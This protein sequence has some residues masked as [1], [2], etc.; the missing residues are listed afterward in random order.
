MR[1]VKFLMAAGAASMMS[2]VALAAD[3]PS[4]A[5]P[6]QM[7]YAPPPAE[8]F[9]GW[10]LRGD[11]GMTN[12]NVKF[13]DT[14]PL[15]SAS[16]DKG[17]DV[18]SATLFGLGVG[19]QFNSW[20]RADV[21]GQY[22]GNAAI[23][24]ST[25]VDYGVGGTSADSYSGNKQE[26]LILANGYVDLGTWW[27]VTP[28]VGAGVGVAN[29][30][31]KGFRDDG[32]NQY[33]GPSYTHS[34]TYFD[35]VSKWNFAWA[36]HAGLAY[37]VTPNVTLELAYSYVD[38]G[39]VSTAGYSQFDGTRGSSSFYKIKDITSHDVK[40]GVRWNLDSPAPAVYA[41]PL[42]RKG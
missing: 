18:S 25:V 36:A 30:N 17:F 27:C 9:G 40:L 19:Y 32:F 14:N 16:Q 34:A 5:P 24:G 29:V 23:H 2:T 12:Q 6:P 33:A 3:M 38:M 21:T 37:K 11:I 42:M 31:L 26:Y 22:R 35:N 10:Y 8:D 41:P 4:I 15:R 13:E 20:F 28:F 1:S 7:M 39:S